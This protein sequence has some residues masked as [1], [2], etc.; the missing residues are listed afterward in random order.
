MVSDSQESFSREM[1][2]FLYALDRAGRK[3]G[4][5]EITGGENIFIQRD[6]ANLRIDARVRATA[7]GDSK[8]N[9]PFAVVRKD[10]TTVTLLGYNAD[11]GRY[12]YNTLILGL[13]SYDVQERDISV[14]ESSWI[15]MKITYD[16]SDYQIEFSAEAEFREQT[17]EEFYIPLALAQCGDD[18]KIT[19]VTQVQYGNIIH[20][21]RVL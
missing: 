8:Y 4:F 20:P 19:R 5:P 9:G 17:E 13:K 14:S 16:G 7:D 21:G 3:P 1:E 2:R 11:K 15:Y 10:D 6:G 18:G 12:W